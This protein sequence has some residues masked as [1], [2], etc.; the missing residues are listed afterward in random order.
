LWRIYV[1]IGAVFLLE[2]FSQASSQQNEYW[3]ECLVQL[4]FLSVTVEIYLKSHRYE[5]FIC[6]ARTNIL[7]LQRTYCHEND[8]WLIVVTYLQ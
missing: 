8:F 6:F 4:N 5:M 1:P 7:L 2:V 3:R